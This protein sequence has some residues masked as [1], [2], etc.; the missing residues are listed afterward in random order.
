MKVSPANPN[1]RMGVR[2][3]DDLSFRIFIETV[4]DYA[5]LMLDPMGYIISWNPGAEAIKG[6]KADEIIGKHFSVFYPPESIESGVPAQELVVAARDGRFEDEGWRV[7]KD[8]TRF[9]ANVIITALHAADG[10][11]TGYAKVTRDLTERRRHEESLRY[12]E[13]RFRALVEGVRD[14]AIYMLDT[15]GSIATWNAGAQKIHGFDAKEMIGTHFSRLLIADGNEKGRASRELGIATREGRFQEEGWRSRKDGSRFWANVVITAIRD[16][17]GALLGFSKITRDLTERR[18]HEAAMLESEERFRLLVESVVDYAIVTLDEEG[19]ITSWNSGA[20]RINGYR[21]GEII[22]RHF[23]R[24]YPAE[25]IRANKPWEQLASARDHGR[26][27]DESWRIRSDGTQYWANNVIAALPETETRR[28]TFYMVTQDLSQRRH[29]ETLA[30]TAQRMHEFIAMLAHELRN[31]LAP[32]RNAVAL[33]ARR[34]SEDPLIEAMRQTID[35]QSQNLTRIVD[36]LLD[37]NRVARG[38]FIIDKQSI[39]LRD[40]LARA[41]E[42]SRPLID[43]HHHRLHVSIADRPIDCFGDPMR[44]TQVVINILNNA[45][46]YTPEDGEIWLSAAQVGEQVEIRIRD[47]GRGIERDALDRVF[48]LFMQIDPNAGSALGGLGVG[49]ALVRRIVELHGGG[50]H[51]FSDGL[52]KGSEFL[53]RLPIVAPA[54][55]KAPENRASPQPDSSPPLRILVIDDNED[56]ANSLCLL[57]Q[58]MGHEVRATYDGPAGIAAAH[59]FTPDVVLLDIGMPVMSGYEVARAL[60]NSSGRPVIVAVTGWGDEAA[61]HKGREAGF[62]QHLV[63]PVTESSL[64]E[65]LADVSRG[66]VAPN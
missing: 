13:T 16:L 47:N 44:L 33:M 46:K 10:S 61:K 14:Y 31:P 41:V 40:V 58:S 52:G 37:V 62:D 17:H 65:L 51:A 55:L 54:R 64:L 59:A 53:V 29:A 23:S 24:L 30:D 34:K 56:A 12:N 32:I 3:V 39:D 50:V 7:R 15:D 4:R 9:W 63:K 28:R 26:V 8:G 42:A 57:M 2:G 20:E 5:L 35:R 60:R 66:R 18:K 48:D 27:N 6:Y 1:P 43:A 38:Q 11:L 22:G 21:A 36:D 19:M 25:D 49:L 45:A